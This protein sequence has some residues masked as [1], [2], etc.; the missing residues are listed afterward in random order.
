MRCMK[1]GTSEERVGVLSFECQCVFAI[2]A[3]AGKVNAADWEGLD[4]PT[5]PSFNAQGVLECTCGRSFPSHTT[6]Q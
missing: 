4:V 6:K 1:E 2:E 5:W 3:G